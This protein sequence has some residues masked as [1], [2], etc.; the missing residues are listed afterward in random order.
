MMLPGLTPPQWGS[1]AWFGFVGR[2]RDSLAAADPVRNASA[3]AD[4]GDLHVLGLLGYD[5]EVP[6]LGLKWPKYKPGV[7]ILPATS[8]AIEGSEHLGYLL[9]A[10]QYAQRYNAT[11]IA[12]SAL[13]AK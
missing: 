8:D 1:A 12:R 2:L 9:V 4:S 6:G 10:R 3:A 5:L 11:I 7:Y 13:I